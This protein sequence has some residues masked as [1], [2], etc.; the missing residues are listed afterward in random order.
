MKRTPVCQRTSLLVLMLSGNEENPDEVN[1]EEEEEK[2]KKFPRDG[3][4]RDLIDTIERDMLIQRPNTKWD[5]IAG[6][7]VAKDLLKEAVVLPLLIPDFFR[8]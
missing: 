2:P 5:S 7:S 1:K 3:P 6:L 4:D 8:G